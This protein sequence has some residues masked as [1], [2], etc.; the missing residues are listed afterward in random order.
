MPAG[1][2]QR[3]QGLQSGNERRDGKRTEGSGN[4]RG[5]TQKHKTQLFGKF[6]A[7]RHNGPEAERALLDVCGHEC[8][9]LPY[10]T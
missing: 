4:K 6:K 2:M 9:A 5:G 10:D 3:G 1:E 7:G 8:A